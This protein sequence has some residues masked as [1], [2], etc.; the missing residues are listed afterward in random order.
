MKRLFTAKNAAAFF[1][2]A[3]LLMPAAGTALA[4]GPGGHHARG[5]NGGCTGDHFA[6]KVQGMKAMLKLTDEQV[7]LL[8]NMH[9]A[10]KALRAKMCTDP[11]AGCT[12]TKEQIRAMYLFRAELAAANPDFPAV[13]DKLK[14]EYQGDAKG[15][16][17]A[18]V[19]A[20]TAFMESLTPEQRD[21][22]L[23]M[24]HHGGPHG[25]MKPCRAVK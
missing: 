10:H 1:I 16:F 22:M 20:R 15:E 21:A 8:D 24:R 18:A 13:A 2:T 17:D 7:T 23:T 14:A 9:E 25:F 4:W 5:M 19:D 3:L 11:A 12:P 6:A